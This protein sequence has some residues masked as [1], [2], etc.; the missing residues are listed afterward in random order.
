MHTVLLNKNTECGL[1]I[2]IRG[3]KNR[4]RTMHKCAYLH[5]HAHKQVYAYTAITLIWTIVMFL[6]SQ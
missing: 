6:F 4:I 1:Q 3:I 2:I 5:M